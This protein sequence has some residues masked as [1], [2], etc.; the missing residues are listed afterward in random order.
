MGT[1]DTTL[2]LDLVP[3]N[4]YLIMKIVPYIEVYVF[5][6]V[7][8]VIFVIQTMTHLACT[9]ALQIALNNKQMKQKCNASVIAQFE[10]AKDK[11][12]LF[13]PYSML[14]VIFI[15]L[16]VR[17]C[18]NVH[19]NMCEYSLEASDSAMPRERSE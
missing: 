12:E 11:H 6:N 10:N 8:S 18:F 2:S 7:S 14:T 19:V 13:I 4:K 5:E 17:N 15:G 3:T 1:V 16:Q 9:S